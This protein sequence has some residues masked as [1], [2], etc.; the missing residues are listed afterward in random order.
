MRPREP[1]MAKYT[2]ASNGHL[3]AGNLYMY[4]HVY[5]CNISS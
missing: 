3:A 2:T 5:V 1:E 4:I